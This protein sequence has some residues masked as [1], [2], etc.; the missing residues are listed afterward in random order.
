MCGIC[1]IY[2]SSDEKLIGRMNETISYRGPDVQN[3]V[4][5]GGKHALGGAKLHITGDLEA[6]FPYCREKGGIY[7]LLNGEI[8][9]YRYW[10][11]RLI[12]KGYLFTTG[13]DTE[14]VWAL[15]HRYGLEF[16]Y[17]LKGMFAVAV[18]DGDKLILVRDRL[19]IKPLFYYR[20]GNR[21][22]FSSE[23]KALFPFISS[24]SLL[25]MSAF[26]EIATFGYI[27][28]PIDTLFEGIAQ[29]KPG[30]YLLFDGED[31]AINNYY[32]PP[33]SFSLPDRQV[34]Y[35]ERRLLLSNVMR[36]SM[37][38]VMQHGNREKGVLLSG[39]VDSSLMAVLATETTGRIKTFTITDGQQAPD[40][41]W[42]RRVAR[43]IKSEHYELEVS[44]EDYLSELPRYVYHYENIV[45]GGVFDLQGGM[46]FHLLC[47]QA[48]QLVKVVLTGEGADELFGGYYWTYTHPLGF[49]DRIRN[50]LK[51]VTKDVPNEQL[52]RQVDQLF[53]LPEDEDRYR[54]NVFDFLLKGGLANYHLWSVDRTSG[55]FGF[56]IRPF[57]LHD[58]I[59]DCGLSIPVEYK[60]SSS[61]VTKVILKDLAKKYF[62]PF[63]L[64]EVAS[65]KKYGMP[66]AFSK[67]DNQLVNFVD[68][69]IADDH[70]QKHPFRQFLFTKTEVL[71][72][73]LFYYI[74]FHN[75]GHL[76]PGFNLEE[77]LAGGIFESMYR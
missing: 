23:I 49:A 72:F 5:V 59:V 74:Y 3:T 39:G 47:K 13:T 12:E 70:F 15:Y 58:D 11:Q 28:S 21:L 17:K 34:D 75:N 36:S 40:L 38:V 48:S 37:Q 24:R 26:Q 53:P 20:E 44:L 64:E 43:A 9:N 68:R 69:R 63:G 1:G 65:R 54:L 22:A 60:V 19:G 46:A 76:D 50:R 33:P 67:I 62:T 18:L 61:C 77:A 8:Y 73:D 30:E 27:C 51:Q 6:P 16:V 42:S 45:A 57:Y 71:M 55:A 7:V 31:I 14:V 25:N 29:V 4:I 35:R 2:G 52:Q 66:A 32:I 56:E 10:Q 41:P